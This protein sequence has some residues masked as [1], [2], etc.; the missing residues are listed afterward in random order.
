MIMNSDNSIASAH[1]TISKIRSGLTSVIRGRDDTIKLVLTGL[2]ADGHVLLE[3][4]PGSGKTTLS[5][6]LGKLISGESQRD[7]L[8]YIAPFRRVQFT[9][10]LLPG[11]VLG[12]NI[13][14]PRNGEFRFVHG[15]V[16][17]HIVLADEINRTGP[18]V[19]AAFLECMAEKQV[20]VDA[21]TYPLDQVFFVIGTQ[22]PLDVAGTYPLPSVQLDRFLLRIPMTYVDAKTELEI[23]KDQSAISEAAQNI[24]PVSS[25]SDILHA[26]AAARKVHVADSVRAAIVS[27]VQAT[28]SHPLIQFGASTRAALMLQNALQSWA[29]I[30]GRDYV[31]EDDLKHLTPF[32]LAHRMKFLGGSKADE[33]LKEVMLQPLETLIRSGLR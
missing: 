22:N 27:I 18:K 13:F 6:T 12:I 26:Q 7:T 4:Y 19:Q 15:P 21:V 14:E 1:E 8:S 9:P 30:E 11:D 20:T 17:A 23:L 32:V 24:K 5:K 10:D 31:T 28:R 2:V 29:L 16:F 3:D 25:R 33:V